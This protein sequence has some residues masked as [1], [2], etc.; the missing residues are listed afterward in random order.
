MSD[1]PISRGDLVLSWGR[2]EKITNELCQMIVNWGGVNILVDIRDNFWRAG[3]LS[4]FLGVYRFPIGELYVAGGLVL[5]AE[6]PVYV[7]GHKRHI[8]RDGQL[9]FIED[10]GIS[11]QVKKHEEKLFVLACLP[12]DDPVGFPRVVVFPNI[13]IR[14]DFKENLCLVQS[15]DEVKTFIRQETKRYCQWRLGKNNPPPFDIEDLEKRVVEEIAKEGAE[16]LPREYNY[17]WTR[18]TGRP[19]LSY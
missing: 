11:S 5:I 9:N 7:K 4:R 17:L 3:T 16:I 10:E 13:E 19:R 8:P 2:R 1:K 18:A 12:R 14:Y 6:W 15:D